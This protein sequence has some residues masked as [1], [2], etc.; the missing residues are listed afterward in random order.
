MK[1]ITGSV[2][3]G[4]TYESVFIYVDINKDTMEKIKRMRDTLL[5]IRKKD[6]LTYDLRAWSYGAVRVYSVDP[7]LYT[8]DNPLFYDIDL[9]KEKIFRYLV[10]NDITSPSEISMLSEDIN[11]DVE[12]KDLIRLKEEYALLCTNK[13]GFYWQ[14]QLESLMKEICTVELKY[15]Y[16]EK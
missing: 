1:L 12:Y 13:N 2:E 11:P 3:Q 5:T 16:L 4:T 10:S 8:I 6:S 15:S 9:Y 7:V 14:I